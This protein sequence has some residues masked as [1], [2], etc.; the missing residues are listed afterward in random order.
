MSE[1]GEQARAEA[2]ADGL[3]RVEKKLDKVLEVLLD[4]ERGL[5]VRMARNEERAVAQA[6]EHEERS[7]AH[8]K[9]HEELKA[10]LDKVKAE[11]LVKDKSLDEVK[12]AL[13]LIKKVGTGAVAALSAVNLPQLAEFLKSLFG[14]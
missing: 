14:G 7:A 5:A 13:R 4:P 6:R 8:A 2:A 10:E 9:A 1:S 3:E 12:A 11:N